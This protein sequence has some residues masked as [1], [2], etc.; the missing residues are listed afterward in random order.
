MGE[1][2]W[3]TELETGGCEWEITLDDAELAEL[4][5]EAA[6]TGLTEDHVLRWRLL[7][8]SVMIET[9]TR[10]LDMIAPISAYYAP[11]S[12]TSPAT[13]HN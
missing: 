1:G 11:R 5:A 12:P 3:K 13:K 10:R 6:V 7:G 2:I 4:Q 8:D 9:F